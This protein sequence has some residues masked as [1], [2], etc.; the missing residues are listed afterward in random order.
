VQPYAPLNDAFHAYGDA[1]AAWQSGQPRTWTGA[2]TTFSVPLPDG[3]NVW[4]FSD[5]FLSPTNGC[6]V[7]EE[8]VCH[9][10]KGFQGFVN[11]TFVV[12]KDGALVQTLAGGTDAQPQ[13]LITPPA[14]ANNA[15]FYWMG[16]G[17]VEGNKLRVF[18]HRYPLAVGTIPPQIATDVATFSTADMRLRSITEGVSSDAVRPWAMTP[19]HDSPIPVIWGAGVME[20]GDYTYIYGTEEY[21]LFKYLHVARVPRGHLLDA[22]WGYWDGSAWAPDAIASVRVLGDVAGELSVGR[23]ADGYRLIASRGGIG[24]PGSISTSRR[25]LRAVRRCTTPM[26]IPS[27]TRRGS[28]SSRTT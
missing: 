24:M 17:T 28:S 25:R 11:N 21:S 27:S 2:D 22:P 4:I 16:D 9:R 7:D 23:T 12:E 10:R 1:G 15:S 19:G 13:A 26:S 14:P 8:G 18:V 6:G 3:R 5:S 20:D